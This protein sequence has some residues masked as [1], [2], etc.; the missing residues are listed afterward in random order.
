[1]GQLSSFSVSIEKQV[2]EKETK[3]KHRCDDYASSFERVLPIRVKNEEKQ[4][5]RFC[6]HFE[7]LSCFSL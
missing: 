7:I 6:I 2:G 5:V 3:K 4:K 1:M